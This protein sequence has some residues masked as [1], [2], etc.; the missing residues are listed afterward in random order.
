MP[1]LPETA[2]MESYSPT[3]GLSCAGPPREFV[4]MKRKRRVRDKRAETRYCAMRRECGVAPLPDCSCWHC[5]NQ[6]AYGK[7]RGYS[8]WHFLSSSQL[9]GPGPLQS[10]WPL[11]KLRFSYGI[12]TNAG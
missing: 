7:R 5:I 4:T 2:P 6:R 1:K 12:Q 10:W 11:A 3:H 9:L 8:R